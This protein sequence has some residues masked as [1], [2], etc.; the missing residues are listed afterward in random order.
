MRN[1]Y[2]LNQ[3]ILETASNTITNMGEYAAYT[4]EKTG[5]SP[6]DKRIVELE[7]RVESDK[8]W[9]GKIINKMEKEIHERNLE[10]VIN[11][12]NNRNK[13]YAV[14]GFAG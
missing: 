3:S 4:D 1:R 10:R 11:Y 7:S 13:L 6:L 8:I 9:W 5:R 12:L 14:H 2:Q